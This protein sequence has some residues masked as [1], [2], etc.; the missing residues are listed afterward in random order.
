MQTDNELRSAVL[1]V[2][3]IIAVIV[4]LTAI[5]N[6][7]ETQSLNNT[8]VNPKTIGEMVGKKTIEGD[9]PLVHIYEYGRY[10]PYMVVDKQPNSSVM[11]IR[12]EPTNDTVQFNDVSVFSSQ[13]NYYPDSNLDVWL[14]DEFVQ[15]FSEPMQEAIL[16][17][18]IEV[19]S[20]ETLLKNEEN[21]KKDIVWRRVF[22]LSTSEYGKDNIM[23]V[24]KE[25]RKIKNLILEEDRQVEWTRSP[26]ND[27]TSMF[28]CAIDG[29]NIIQMSVD[30]RLKV[31]PAFTVSPLL[32]IEKREDPITGEEYFVLF[33]TD[34]NGNKIYF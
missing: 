24:L 5:V 3:I 25:G 6:I 10:V 13:Y 34:K 28:S 1:I 7:Q 21:S 33:S 14:N 16:D 22:V 11:L 19:T 29:K 15:R 23:T 20:L 31:R 30:E 18:R 2:F 4:F 12:K 27:G 8:I 26:F 17:T 32:A 9:V